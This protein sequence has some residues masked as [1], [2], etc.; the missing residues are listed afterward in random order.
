MLQG[1][2]NATDIL[3]VG[4]GFLADVA[5]AATVH[6][7]PGAHVRRAL[8]ELRFIGQWPQLVQAH[9]TGFAYPENV[10]VE[11]VLARGEQPGQFVNSRLIVQIHHKAPLTIRS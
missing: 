5:L 11:C 8:L 9:F 10:A 7:Q 1:L 4:G 3:G 6:L 2:Q